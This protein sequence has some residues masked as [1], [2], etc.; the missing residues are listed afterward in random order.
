MAR[1]MSKTILKLHA[2]WLVPAAVGGLAMDI[3]GAFFQRGPWMPLLELAPDAAI[4]M[5]E[6]HG[7]ALLIGLLLWNAPS[8]RLWHGVGL[9][10]GLLLG[11]ANLTFWRVFEISDALVGGYV[12][13]GF[14]FLFAGLQLWAMQRQA[15]PTTNTQLVVPEPPMLSAANRRAPGTWQSPARPETW[16]AQSSTWRTPVAPT[17]WPQPM[18]PPEGLIGSLPPASM[19]P[20]SIAFQDSPGA[21]RPKWSMAMYSDVVKQSWVSMPERD[22]QSAMPARR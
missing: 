8:A 4:G 7:L 17:G 14:H 18:R 20:S 2:A 3:A 15:A 6:A 13:T 19:V 10:V 12:T 5:V 21:V 22:Q 9:A 16:R 1:V 11:T